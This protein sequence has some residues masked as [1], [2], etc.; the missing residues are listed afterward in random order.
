MENAALFGTPLNSPVKVYAKTMPCCVG[1]PCNGRLF[2]YLTRASSGDG[3]KA[4]KSSLRTLIGRLHA[5]RFSRLSL[6]LREN[7]SQG[8]ER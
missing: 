4:V 2:N 8:P 1:K 5:G 3:G 7:E 6:L